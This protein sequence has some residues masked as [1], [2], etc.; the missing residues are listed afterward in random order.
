MNWLNKLTE[1]IIEANP[2][3]E[4]VVSS[5]VSPSGK[6]H[7]GTLR[8]LMTAEVIARELRNRGRKCRHLHIVDDLDV[9]RKVPAGID[10][11]YD[12][13]KGI[14]LCDVPSPDGSD[15]SYA[16]Y[17][18]HDLKR[19]VKELNFDVDIIRA[20][21][22]YR[23]G[24]F[25]EPIERSLDNISEIRTILEQISGHK[26]DDNWS[27][28][29]VLEGE[30]LKNRKFMSINTEK[31]EIT[32]ID[33]DGKE[34][35]TNYQRGQVKLNW[36]IDWP[37]R[38][39]KLG[40]DVEPFGRDHATKGG[41]YDTGEVI[42][43]KVFGYDPPIPVPYNFINRAGDTKKM[44]KS[45]G[46]T[47]TLSELLEVMPSEIVW[48]FMLRYAPGKQLFFDEG[49]TL[50]RLIDE[51]SE[52]LSKTDKTKED[53]Q[54]I[55]LCSE[56]IST[57]TISGIPF[58]HLVE[59]YQASLRDSAKTLQILSRTEYKT[60]VDK[61]TE[62][63]KNELK[64]IDKWLDKWAPEEIKFELVKSINSES[65]DSVQK[66]FLSELANKIAAL[67]D[68]AEGED[69]HKAI[70]E[71]KDEIDMTPKDMFRTI[72][73]VTIGKTSGPRAG[74][75]LHALPRDWLIKRLKLEN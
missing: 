54:M 52:L 40:V 68:N 59:S 70:Y 12:K 41:S 28:V 58:T 3:G 42:A 74:W 34:Q 17:Y 19:A 38:W 45:A 49:S 25:V 20:N 43:K 64:F 63:I 4:I 37:A 26:L 27:P 2:E 51:Y 31:K 33:K 35:I 8:E 69:F 29:Q 13:Y 44:S 50:I 7:I 5:G 30:Y 55:E 9:F 21:E 32:Y 72:Y 18:L 60:T 36:R 62:I 48:Y 14:P 11:S 6:Y 65:F 73:K 57:R 23:Q 61:E 39:W 22:K 53:E 1:E 75:F 67:P 71:F 10:D 47:I 16:D 66:D 24:F 56:G 15:K 46:N